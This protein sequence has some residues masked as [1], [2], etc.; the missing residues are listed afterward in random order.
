[1]EGVGVYP[2]CRSVLLRKVLAEVFPDR[3][4]VDAEFVRNYGVSLVPPVAAQRGPNEVGS[5]YR[6]F[7]AGILTW[8]SQALEHVIN[9]VQFLHG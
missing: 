7:F 9:C 2:K 5:K 4:F 1:M 6:I 8:K 3:R